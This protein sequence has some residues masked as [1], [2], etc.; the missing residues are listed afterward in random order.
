MIGFEKSLLLFASYGFL[1]VEQDRLPVFC[2][3]DYFWEHHWNKDKEEKWE[4]Y[5]RVMR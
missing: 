3:N 1:Y 5:A 2:P 4:A